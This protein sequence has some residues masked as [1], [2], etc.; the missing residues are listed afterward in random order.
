MIKGDYR[1]GDKKSLAG[2]QKNFIEAYKREFGFVLEKRSII[3]DDIRY[4]NLSYFLK[5]RDR[6]SPIA[7]IRVILR[8]S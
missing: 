7:D 1:K 3:V 8:F 2:Y 4:S 6:C 5:T